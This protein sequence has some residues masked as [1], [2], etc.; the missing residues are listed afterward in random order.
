MPMSERKKSFATY[1]I[2]F[3]FVVIC[4]LVVRLIPWPL[5]LGIGV[6][7]ALGLALLS[8]AAVP[9]FWDPRVSNRL[10]FGLP[11]AIGL[12]FGALTSMQAFLDP[13]HGAVTPFPQSILIFAAGGII[14]ETLLRLFGTTVLTALFRF[15]SKSEIAYW[16]AAT[17]ASLY[18]PLPYL[19]HPHASALLIAAR[20]LAFNLA[21][22]W[23]YR[24]AGFV[25]AVMLRWSEYLVWHIVVQTMFGLT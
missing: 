20:L 1:A 4:A 3:V 2:A 7:G 23:V 24:R 22:A 8:R 9:E 12:A 21:G 6:A 13:H 17:I 19:Q 25:A 16:V 10:R 14:L 11:V 18:E 5:I 15:I